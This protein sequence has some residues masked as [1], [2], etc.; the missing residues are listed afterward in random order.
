VKK[1]ERRK[2]DLGGFW[3]QQACKKGESLPGEEEINSGVLRMTEFELIIING[4]PVVAFVAGAI[5]STL[6]A[7]LEQ[8]FETKTLCLDLIQSELDELVKEEVRKR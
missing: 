6:H 5:D 4:K 7:T 2:T 1:N 3:D 8:D